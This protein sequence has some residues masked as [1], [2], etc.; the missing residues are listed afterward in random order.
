MSQYVLADDLDLCAPSTH[1]IVGKAAPWPE[2]VGREDEC[3]SCKSTAGSPPPRATGH[4]GSP[5]AT[6]KG[7]MWFQ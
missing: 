7:K 2:P 3:M 5:C 4:G 6:R 1:H